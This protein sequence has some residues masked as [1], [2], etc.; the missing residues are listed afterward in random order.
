LETGLVERDLPL[1][2]AILPTI[3]I[4]LC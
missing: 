2:Y 4:I 3:V 1:M